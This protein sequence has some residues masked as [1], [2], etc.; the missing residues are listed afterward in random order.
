MGSTTSRRARGGCLLKPTNGFETWS[1]IKG[2]NLKSTCFL[3]AFILN[4]IYFTL[5]TWITATSVQSLD[6]AIIAAEKKNAALRRASLWGASLLVSMVSSFG[7]YLIMHLV[8]GS[9]GGVVS[10]GARVDDRHVWALERL[11]QHTSYLK[12]ARRAGLLRA[13]QAA[14]VSPPQVSGLRF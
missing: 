5:L 1:G 14:G 6:H 11:I 13:A 4:S 10:V 12:P 2:V 9:G 3:N 7:L 8:F